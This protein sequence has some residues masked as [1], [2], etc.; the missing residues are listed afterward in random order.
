MFSYNY[1]TDLRNN[2]NV[3]VNSLRGKQ[4]IYKYIKNFKGGS[5]RLSFTS[6]KINLKIEQSIPN[7]KTMLK[8]INEKYPSK[9][10]TVDILQL[11]D[12]F[13][14]L[15]Y[16]DQWEF[17]STEDFGSYIYIKYD[18]EV[19]IY[20]KILD[21]VK[22]EFRL[23]YPIRLDFII[24][25]RNE[26]KGYHYTGLNNSLV[27]GKF[28]WIPVKKLSQFLLNLD[29]TKFKQESCI[30]S[31][32]DKFLSQ[33]KGHNLLS[34]I[35]EKKL[36]LKRLYIEKAH[37][38]MEVIEDT[39][40]KNLVEAIEKSML[41]KKYEI[42]IDLLDKS[43]SD[44]ELQKMIY[45][46][47]IKEPFILY[48]L[49]KDISYHIYLNN[50]PENI[51]LKFIIN[52][53]L[54]S[55][56][57]NSD[58]DIFFDRFNW[59][60]SEKNLYNFLKNLDL[61]KIENSEEIININETTKFIQNQEEIHRLAGTPASLDYTTCGFEISIECEYIMSKRRC[62]YKVYPVHAYRQDDIQN[63]FHLFT[64]LELAKSKSNNYSHIPWIIE[65]DGKELEIV[66]PTFYVKKDNLELNIKKI[67]E[68]IQT[69][70]DFY[71]LK[72]KKKEILFF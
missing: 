34:A 29:K 17:K 71:L 3:Y 33:L 28:K 50:Y 48:R 22:G 47:D 70:L 62:Y 43:L 53:E 67:K 1:I 42:I 56:L 19:D 49:N 37:S 24:F 36:E 35:L 25:F 20:I 6:E 23:I 2:K 57:C 14:H 38:A 26:T 52:N 32:T 31:D 45:I 66:T 51:Q 55:Y 39:N 27:L 10:I 4:I 40:I 44:S 11:I 68:F 69:I 72:K 64:H 59:R 15:P 61:S 46:E 7:I 41:K 30:F 12:E 60:Y 9:R 5:S 58:Q 16:L 54:I 18:H 65:T 13:P 8:L 21:I 63:V